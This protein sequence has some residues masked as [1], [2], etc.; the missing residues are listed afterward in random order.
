MH[1]FFIA[2]LK[3]AF[4]GEQGTITP[5]N[6]SPLTDGAASVWVADAEG[7][8][9]LAPDAP[10]VRLVDWEQAAVD[11]DAE[12]RGSSHQIGIRAVIELAATLKLLM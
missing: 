9:R 3:P 4:G 2:R 5:G 11:I 7:R 12:I 8:H 10:V 6:S 1:A